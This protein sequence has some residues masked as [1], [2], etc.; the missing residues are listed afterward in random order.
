MDDSGGKE[1]TLIFAFLVGFLGLFALSIVCGII[2]PR[3]RLHLHRRYGIFDVPESQRTRPTSHS[4]VPQLWDVWAREV[5]LGARRWDCAWERLNPLAVCTSTGRNPVGKSHSHSAG[6]STPGKSVFHMS[7]RTDRRED[8]LSVLDVQDGSVAVVIT[9]PLCPSFKHE[10]Q[11]SDFAL[12]VA[13]VRCRGPTPQAHDD[14]GG[15][16]VPPQAV[17]EHIET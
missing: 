15:G 12:G 4:V 2:W 3:A 5:V 8:E 13:Q 17:I 14:D 10:Q 7:R 6:T 11:L 16:V 1:S 9:M